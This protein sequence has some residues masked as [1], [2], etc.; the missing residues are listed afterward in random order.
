[1][2]ATPAPWQVDQMCGL[3]PSLTRRSWDEVQIEQ[4]SH[5]ILLY[6]FNLGPNLRVLSLVNEKLII[7][8]EKQIILLLVIQ[9]IGVNRRNA[10][11]LL[12]ENL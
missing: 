5:P 11:I 9:S 8:L 4:L 1:M 7:C 6:W 12:V 3:A 10:R 2:L